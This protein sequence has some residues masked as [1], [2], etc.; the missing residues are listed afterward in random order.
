MLGVSCQQVPGFDG[1]P[2]RLVRR[3]QVP[4]GLPKKKGAQGLGSLRVLPHGLLG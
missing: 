3:I 2:P 4:L 1:S